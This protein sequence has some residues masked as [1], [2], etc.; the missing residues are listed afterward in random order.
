MNFKKLTCYLAVISN[1]LNITNTLI[2]AGADL[3]IV[4][5]FGYKPLDCGTY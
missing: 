1:N 5:I 3:N 2:N 4:D